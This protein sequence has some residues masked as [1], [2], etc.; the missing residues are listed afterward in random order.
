MKFSTK[1][2]AIASI[3]ALAAVAN[4]AAGV[5]TET[6]PN[7]VL[8]MSDD[9]GYSDI[10]C[11]GGEIDTPTL[12]SLAENGLRFTQYYNTARCCPTR[13]ALLSGV[14]QHQAG[15]GLMTGDGMR[16]EIQLQEKWAGGVHE[17]RVQ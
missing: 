4:A 12:N 11:Y 2:Y 15:I 8:I 13:A 9:M 5:G 10:G 7:I 17:W 1:R 6:P 16:V 14:Y 3:V